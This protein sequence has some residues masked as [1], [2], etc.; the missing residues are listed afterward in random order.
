MSKIYGYCRISTPKQNIDR[1]VR[2]ILSAHSDAIIVKETFTGTKFYGR[3]EFENKILKKIQPGDTI[4]FDAVDRMSRDAEEGFQLYEE[5]FLKD[6]N[7]EFIKNPEINTDVYRQARSQC[8]SLSINSGDSAL[9]ELMTGITD[10]INRY[11]MELAKRQIKVAFD[12]A[13]HEVKSL[14]DRTREGIETARRKGKQIGQ[15]P[16]AKL[17]TQKSLTAKQVILEH[18]KNFGGGYLKN[19]EIMKLAGISMVTLLKYKQELTEEIE[20]SS[21]EEVVKKYKHSK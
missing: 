3:K 14:H 18:S 13:E 10:A 6:I 1:Q 17:T 15:K 16:G 5:L 11:I 2:N 20:N 21:Y 4:V 9:D 7:L 12:R 19:E 8:L